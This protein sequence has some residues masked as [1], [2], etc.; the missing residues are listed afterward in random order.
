MKTIYNTI[1]LLYIV[2]SANAQI[3]GTLDD[4]FLPNNSGEKGANGVIFDAVE[5]A[6]GKI[7]IG[8]W[9]SGYNDI[10]KNRL[11]R[12]NPDGSMDESFNQTFL[13]SSGNAGVTALA[14]QPDGKILVGGNFDVLSSGNL[15]SEGLL[16]LNPDGTIDSTFLSSASNLFCSNEIYSIS[17]Q[18]DGKIILAG[19]ITFCL[20]NPLN[21]NENILRLNSD[22]TIDDTF[23]AEIDET[24]LPGTAEIYN[25][26]IQPDG[27]ILV[28]GYFN[29]SNGVSSPY[30]TR[31]NPDGSNDTS[32]NIGTGFDDDV[33]DI[34]LQTNGK[35]LVVGD[36][37]NYNGSLHS[38][39]IRLNP[40][41]STDTSFDVGLGPQNEFS[42]GSAS[43]SNLED[44]SVQPDGKIIVS[45]GFNLFDGTTVSQVARLNN[46][47]SLDNTFNNS[48]SSP[49]FPTVL[50]TRVLN[51]N[52]ILYTGSF[53]EFLNYKRDYIL[54]LTPAGSLDFTFNTNNG[55]S[56]G[57]TDAVIINDI[58][59]SAAGYFVAGQFNE[60]DNLL[61]RNVAKINADGS[62]DLNFSTGNGEDN[63]FDDEVFGM[64]V[65]SD[66]KLIATGDFD[67]YNGNAVGKI[68]R[69]NSDGSF[70]SSFNSG[71]GFNSRPNDIEMQA[72][73]KL[74]VAGIFNSYNGSTVDRLVRLNAD[75]SLDQS[76]SASISFVP[77]V[78]S[79]D[80]NNKIYIGG[81]GDLI[82]L[83]A[84]GSV[85]LGFNFNDNSL[86]STFKVNDIVVDDTGNALY[87][88]GYFLESFSSP[89]KI[90]LKLNMDGTLD[91]TFNLIEIDNEA[92]SV[93][94]QSDG[95]LLVGGD[96][97]NVTD[98]SNSVN[99]DIRGIIRLYADGTF[100]DTFNPDQFTNEPEGVDVES[101]FPGAVRSL[102]LDN[103]GRLIV[104]GN[105]FSYNK[106]LKLPLI[107]VH[108]FN[109]VQN[110]INIPDPNFEQALIDVG[111]DSDGIINGQMLESNAL[112][113]VDLDVS[114]KN[115][116][117]LTGIEFFTDLQT[118]SAF[119]N[120]LS[121]IDLS[122]NVNLDTALLA[123]NNL[124]SI[125]FS[126]NPDLISISLNEN[127]LA[128][129][130][131]S[132]NIALLQVFV[133]NNNLSNI[134]VSMLSNLENLGVSSNNLTNLDISQ[135]PNLFTLFCNDNQLQSLNVQNGN[136][137]NFTNF[138]AQNNPNL[139]CITVDDVNYSNTN[140]LNATPQFNFDTQSY[141][142][143]DCSNLI[144]IPDPNFEQALIDL[145]IDT[146]MTINGVTSLSN[147]NGVTTLD[148]SNKNIS[149]L[150]GIEFFNNLQFLTADNNS[151]STLVLDQNTQLIT[152]ALFQNQLSSIVLPDNNMTSIDLGNNLLTQIDL[153]NNLN[154]S[155][156]FVNNNLID[157]IDV[158]MLSNLN[159]LDASG[160]NLT[161][162]DLSPNTVLSQIDVSGNDLSTL[163]VQNGNNTSFTSFEAQNNP[164]LSC[165]T[166]DDV[167]YS[168]TNWLNATPQFNFDTQSYFSPDCSNLISIPDPNFEQAL[169]DLDIDTDMIVNGVTS[170]SNVNGVTT[171][172]ISNKNISDLTGIE[173][174]N[175]L[176]FLTADNNS[177]TTLVLD[178]NTQ[179]ITL[180]IFQNQLSSIV[181]PDN[182]V[183]SSIDLGNNLLTQ[184]DLSNN[185]NLSSVFVNNNLIDDI[186]VS[187]LSNLNILDVSGNNLTQLD[188]S[189]NTVLS[190]IDVS[191]NNLINFNLQN[192][193]NTSISD[194]NFN[195]TNNSNLTCIEV[196]NPTYSF[197]TWFN[198]DPQTDFSSECEPDNDDCIDAPLLAYNIPTPGTTF[199]STPSGLDPGC[200]QSGITIFDV[201]YKL[202]GPAS[203]IIS[204]SINGG[205]LLKV[206]VYDDCMAALPIACGVDG[207]LVDNLIPGVDYF[208]QVWVDAG[209]S[210]LLPQN[211]TAF[212]GD[213]TIEITE[214]TMSTTDFKNAV[215]FSF[216]PNP[217]K[218]LITLNATQSIDSCQIFTINGRE[219]LNV[220]EVNSVEKKI[221]ISKL[222]SG[223]YLLKVNS[224]ATGMTQKL[225]IE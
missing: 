2:I 164:N 15:E 202:E 43:S 154:L 85:D 44:V 25:T 93:Q 73:G 12:I 86:Y 106:Q 160:N 135:N 87:V 130:D 66:G 170:L 209:P 11:V 77:E 52:S 148:I 132:N 113:V 203:G 26:I 161:Q 42:P 133:N 58:E 6:D 192:G 180:G 97:E 53:D 114:S 55:P 103:N 121:V 110:F 64:V 67:N 62:V 216:Y 34:A 3:Q 81:F 79:V 144:S 38:K 95:K 197:N 166:V 39:I 17:V 199:S 218:D 118:L 116:S 204:I 70:D 54:K 159:I 224:G 194:S 137:T 184:I 123:I 9:F 185:L 63:G 190:Q 50:N 141:F 181:L 186:D 171:L 57:A 189:P 13:S 33:N 75:G 32:F 122:Q 99:R 168:N 49:Q 5:Q 101:G 173:F 111:I 215:E 76:L 80:S 183:L 82:R 172:D 179:L 16:R 46:D 201:W 191:D 35:I 71:T 195:A 60:Y 1:I 219:V 175:N 139:S 94:L 210:G 126:N 100:D 155:S 59:E 68:A 221:D 151:I 134:D 178:Q 91:P 177:I 127:N 212:V 23:T 104:G 36:F 83:N 119:N 217:A 182:N 124:T 165:I 213:F 196:D 206:A 24:G 125:D 65:Q 108:A 211:D 105:F 223:I 128:S 84:D 198:K 158:S 138:E 10:E 89:R 4:S 51:D 208:I 152:V 107:A 47:G 78:V 90:L 163:N 120:N 40:D 18:S 129:I 142:S 200:Q 176:Q 222:S 140:W 149:D 28:S 92:F 45:G 29:E 102:S 131:L 19:D 174:F 193:N 30:L 98:N 188:L 112:G 187:M 72:D 214:E 167:N 21:N 109:D 207:I 157:D 8:G 220:S 145:N 41:G 27:K 69:L 56:N 61:S 147:V 143:P 7:I 150:T 115:I 136:N 205:G 14:I 146:D 169:I 37:D 117:D 88:A 31:L 96:I 156:V 153:S 225:I 74:L 20:G 48:I 22:G 162:L